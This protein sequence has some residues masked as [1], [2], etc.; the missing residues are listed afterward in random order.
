MSA[1][2][3]FLCTGNYYRSRYAEVLF[4]T[5]VR[6]RGL[7]WSVSSRGLWQGPSPTRGRV[8]VHALRALEAAGL[9]DHR[10]LRR[11]PVQVT[12]A[13][14]DAADRVI[15]LDEEEHRPMLE[16]RFPDRPV[17]YWRVRDVQ[18]W[19][20]ERALPLIE[21]EVEGLLARLPS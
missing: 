8:S 5:G 20:P 6:R 18:F 19:R 4:E 12:D 11:M 9:A 1:H 15:A 21:R 14:F 2:L 3:L 17:A 7:A 16:A 13:D 10:S